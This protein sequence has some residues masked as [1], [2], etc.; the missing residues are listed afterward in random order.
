MSDK[1]PKVD[2]YGQRELDKAEKKFE[3]FDDQC[4][5]IASESIDKVPIEEKEEQTKLSE[6]EK[7]KMD[8]IWLKPERVISCG[9]QK[10]N[11]KYRESYNFDKE[12]VAFIAEHHEII[13]EV[14]EIWTRPYGGMPAEYWKVPT[15]QKVYGPRYLA[16]QIKKCRYTRLTTEDKITSSDGVGKFYGQLVAEKRVQRL[17]AIPVSERKSIFMGVGA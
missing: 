17:D 6:K 1:K 8:G 11:E 3:E 4:K 5:K 16:E 10:F 15:N 2:S 13:G 12:F 14:I 9:D 7:Q